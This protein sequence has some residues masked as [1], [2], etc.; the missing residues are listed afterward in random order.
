MKILI[1]GPR[2]FIASH[3]LQKAAGHEVCTLDRE[4]PTEELPA[5]F[6][7]EKFEAVVHLATRF[8]KTHD[9]GEIDSLVDSNVT[10]TA[11]LLECASQSGVRHFIAFGTYYEFPK[12]ASLYAATKAAMAPILDFYAK[13]GHL[14]VTELY[15]YDTY[16][17]KDPRPKILNLLIKAA[18]SGEELPLSP[19]LQKMKLLH[20]DD[21]CQAILHTLTLPSGPAAHDVARY[22]LEPLESLTLREIAA[23]VETATYC[24]L[25][26]KWGA[27]EYAPGVQMEPRLPFSPLPGWTA[28]IP[29]QQG[30]VE[31]AKNC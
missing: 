19:G 29:L 20:V 7:R 17:P 9:L 30:L 28:K 5:L 27:R 10:L 21:V 2:G 8:S 6:K 14:Q 13:L 3:L 1:T 12:P 22:A 18:T 4:I 25:N 31:V 16:G 26:A 24:K 11:R 23:K 15:L